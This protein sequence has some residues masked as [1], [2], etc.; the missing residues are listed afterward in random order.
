MILHDLYYFAKPAIP[1]RF[2]LAFRRIL[3]ENLRR[4]HGDTWPINGAASKVPIKWQGWPEGKTFA[5]VLTHDVEGKKGLERSRELA[6]LEIELGFRSSFNF[7]PEGEYR[8]PDS[9][10]RFLIANGFEVGVHDLHHDGS[11]YR[12]R[13]NF[14]SAAKKINR[15]V[16]QWGAEG[17]RSGFMR[18]NLSWLDEI[19]VV[20]DSSTFD[21]DPFEPQPEGV[22]TIFPFWVSQDGLH[23][24]VE[25]PYTLPQDSTMFLLLKENS[26]DIWK[27][28]L[29]WVAEKGGLALVNVHPDYMSFNGQIRLGEYSQQF[30]RDLL[31]YVS[32]RYSDQCWFALPREV[33]R[34]FYSTTVAGSGLNRC[35]VGRETA[36]A[37]PAQDDILPEKPVSDQVVDRPEFSSPSISCLQGKR[38][39]AVSFSTFPGDPRP[40]R[41]AESFVHAGMN[42]E[43]L[44][45]MHEGSLKRETFHG[46][47][48]ER[49]PLKHTRG[50]KLN[51]VLRYCLFIL[52]VFAKLA[53]RSLTRR[54][55]VVHIHNMPDVL[56]FA[57]FVPKCLG[58][59]VILD[60]HDPMPEL[61]MTIFNL[62]TESRAVALMGS[63]EKWS[64]A[65]SDVVLTVNRACEKLFAS[66]SC[67]PSKVSVV[68]NS[69][70]E[71]IF[72]YSPAQIS[73][74]QSDEANAPFII[75]FHGT[76]VERNGVDLAVEATIKLRHYIPAAELRIYGP[77]TPFLD[78]V[79]ATVSEKGLEKAVHYLGP[80]C[81]EQLAQDIA[82]CDVGV[83]P[84]KRSI[85]TE[86]NTPTRIFEYL[87][88][89]KPV[90]APR[91]PGIQDY[92]NEHSLVLFEL[93]NAGDLAR[94]LTWVATHPR[95]SLEITSRG[96]AVY[97]SHSWQVER[98]KLLALV[99]KVLN[100]VPLSSRMSR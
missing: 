17:F 39:V 23:G 44:C 97:R 10:R 7:V 34:Y 35:L 61:M 16:E 59:K 70:D 89:G 65:F 79:M 75:M 18:H 54:Y 87:A 73:T 84:N 77:W 1:L 62:R 15:Y 20:Y 9:W 90:V 4:K 81:L 52:I 63:L 22:E 58:A 56:V 32:N 8:L 74:R 24:Y 37:C 76:L 25:L 92:F 2:R 60:L 69:P 45:L 47:E 3:A 36:R 30:Y 13:R 88:L 100:P 51:Y 48:V 46:I 85:F 55:H 99:V 82:E 5:F 96:Q 93:G 38:V 42:V 12:S 43:V 33:A 11:L 6:E 83:I 80:R 29:D 98:E 67:S 94:K 53:V 28:K 49:I 41:A 68:M 72:K 50:S 31:K 14:I 64:I 26:I 27:R 66:R 71:R 57:S 86:I 21:T 95:E 78:E 91:A 40:R 19:Q